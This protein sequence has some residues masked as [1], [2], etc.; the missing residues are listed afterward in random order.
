MSHRN[1]VQAKSAAILALTAGL[2]LAPAPSIAAAAPTPVVASTSV[3]HSLHLTGAPN[4]RDLGGYTTTDGKSVRSGLV[5][6]SDALT[7]LTAD[8]LAKLVQLNVKTVEDLR[9]TYERVLGP[10]KLPAGATSQHRDVTGGNLVTAITMKDL[11]QFYKVMP[12]NSDASAAFRAVLL[13]IKNSPD[14]V[15]YHCK[16]GKDRTGWLSAVLLTIL[17]VPRETVNADFMLSNEYVGA[18]GGTGSLGSSNSDHVEQAWLDSAFATVDQKYGSFDNY[19]SQALG[20]T[21]QDVTALK[22]KLLS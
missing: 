5:L 16:S 12:S 10:D 11:G 2:L 6:R 17:G 19:V 18:G 8:D 1:L 4:A 3:D 21:N 7:A 15:L 9:T 20:L 22:A 14:T 13:D